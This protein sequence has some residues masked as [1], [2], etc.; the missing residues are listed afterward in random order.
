MY[1]IYARNVNDALPQGMEL[2]RQM[3]DTRSSRNG[4][5]IVAP[6]PV[7]TVYKN[8]TER[9]L[10]SRERDA[11]P[12]FHL[13]EALWM[14]AGENRLKYLTPFVARMAQYSD[15][16]GNTQPGAYGYRWR[17]FFDRDQLTWAAARLAKDPDDRRVVIQMYD[18]DTDQVAADSGGKD[19]PCNLLVLPLIQRGKL[20]ITVVCRSND[21]IWGA[22]GANAVHFSVL[23]EYLA[24]AIGVP[25]G[26]M[27][28]LSNNFHVYMETMVKGYGQP[29]DRYRMLGYR[30]MPL[31]RTDA[32]E[33]VRDFDEDL[34][35]FLGDP[36][37]VGHRNAFL[38]TVACP[39]VMAHRSYKKG[40]GDHAL[41]IMEQVAAP[42][43]RAAGIE[44]LRRREAATLKAA[45]DG[46][47]HDA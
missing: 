17:R 28:Q 12:F 18:A 35:R 47:P 2:L 26:F 14:L 8:P 19:I 42:D 30:P 31:F 5:V 25:V 10:F 16:R 40:F 27:Y 21:M 32:G 29:D 45:D 6:G 4:S 24:A 43:W 38:R 22:Y 23:Q 11:N 39:M 15:D 20:D 13:F 3:G 37:A 44:W 34:N 7:M 41:E 46:V 36:A 9:V 33:R 1:T